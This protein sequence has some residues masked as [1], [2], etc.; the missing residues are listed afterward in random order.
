MIQ[1][2]GITTVWTFDQ[3]RTKAFFTEKLDFEVR[4]EVAMGE[5]TWVTVGAK[6][7]EGV[8]LALMSLDG[9]GLDPESAEALKK[10]VA[11]GV[12]GA[13][14]FRTDDCRGDYETFRARGVEFIQEPQERPYGIEA[15]FRD[16]NGNWYS[17]TQRSAELDFSKDF[18]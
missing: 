13:G 7:Q 16:D 8:E 1:G 12:M 18:G 9:P 14:A 5:M 4:S 10:L 2:L 3:Q 15:I 11:K 6:E 17:L